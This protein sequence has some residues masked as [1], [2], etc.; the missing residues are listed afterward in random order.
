MLVYS[1]KLES[2]ANGL[3]MPTTTI[4]AY[5]KGIEKARKQAAEQQHKTADEL[6]Q[7]NLAGA[8][9]E[10]EVWCQQ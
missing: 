9:E 4:H 3:V 8:S 7:K 1:V 2:A 5:S 10:W 6:K